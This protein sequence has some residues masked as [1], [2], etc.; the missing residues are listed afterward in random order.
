MAADRLTLFG[1]QRITLLAPPP[2]DYG[3]PTHAFQAFYSVR[4]DHEGA[5]TAPDPDSECDAAEWLAR[6]EVARRCPDAAW[7]PLHAAL[8][9]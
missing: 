6:D 4:L 1:G 8:F 9:G 3:Y 2:A 7:L 5:A